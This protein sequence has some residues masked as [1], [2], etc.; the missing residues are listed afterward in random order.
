MVLADSS[1]WIDHLREASAPLLELIAGD[2]LVMHP[3]VIGEVALGSIK[4]RDTI[5]GDMSDLTGCE[6]AEH[7][8]VMALIT[9]YRLHGRGIGHVDAHLLAATLLTPGTRL[10]TRDRRLREAAETLGIA[11]ALG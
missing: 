9:R 3:Y 2:Q 11:A 7:D 5:I 4:D 1:I 6:V 10:W 8:E